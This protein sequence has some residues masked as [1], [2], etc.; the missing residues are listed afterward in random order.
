MKRKKQY[1]VTAIA[2]VALTCAIGIGQSLAMSNNGEQMG[3]LTA[4]GDI[5]G[6]SIKQQQATMKPSF[7]DQYIPGTTVNVTAP[8]PYLMKNTDSKATLAATTT[9]GNTSSAT[10]AISSDI[11]ANTTKLTTG[12]LQSM[13]ATDIALASAIDRD[14]I[15]AATVNAD[16]ANLGVSLR[17]AS[18]INGISG[19]N[20]ASANAARAIKSELGARFAAFNAS[21]YCANS[22]SGYPTSSMT[23]NSA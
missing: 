10:T 9:L 22:L 1:L 8:A 5:N 7:M 14:F 3:I 20:S 23:I 11:M 4:A 13:V 2:I 12:D 19:L 21:S 17:V 16:P 15:R 6:S 18:I